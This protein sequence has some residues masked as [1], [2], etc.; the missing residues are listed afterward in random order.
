M[1]KLLPCLLAASALAAGPAHASELHV[2]IPKLDRTAEGIYASVQVE[3]KNGWRN[4]RNYDAVWLLF[5]ASGAERPWPHVRIAGTGHSV[6]A[7]AGPPGGV[8]VA[9]G[10]VGAFLLPTADHRGPVKWDVRLRLNAR[11]V[12]T[13][14][15][16]A[17]GLE[18]VYV[19]EGAF[20]LGDPDPAGVDYNAVYRS[21]ARGEPDGLYRVDSEDAIAVGP[22]RGALFYKTKNPQFEGDRLGPIPAAFPKGVAPFYT[23]KYEITQGEYA[24]FLNTLGDHATAHRAIHGGHLY[25]ASRGTIRLDGSTYVAGAPARPANFIGWDDG[26]GFADWAGLRPMTE[27]EFTKAA[28][29]T[30]MPLP[31]DFPWGTASADR[32][33]RVIGDDDDL[34]TTGAAD[35]STLSDATR[36][37]L[38]ASFYWVMDLAGS[39][40]EKVITFGHPR[41]RA[42]RGTHGDGHL[43]DRGNATNDDWPLG[44]DDAGGYGYRG[45]GYYERGMKPREYVPYSPTE[46]RRYGSWGGGPRSIAYGFRAVR[47]A[48]QPRPDLANEL[49]QIAAASGGTLGVRV[50]HAETRAAAG[51]NDDDWYP[52]MSAYKLPIAI[53]ALRQAEAGRLNLAKTVT[54]GTDDRR[55]GFSP[56]A[57]LIEKDGPQTMTLRDLLSAILRVSDNTASDRVLREIGGPPAVAATL[58]ELRIDGVDVSRSELQ[59]AADYYGVKIPAPYSLERFIDATERVPP[60]ARR[61]AAAAY[62]ADRRDAAQPR[63]FADLLVRFHRGE[64]LT[65]ENTAWV[66]GEMREMHARDTRLRAGLPP[67]TAAALRPGTSGETDGVRAAHNDNAIVTLPDG[68]HLVIAAFLKGSKGTD[69]DRDAVLARVARVAYAWATR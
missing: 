28:R 47:T 16:R 33:A 17:F 6:A 14:E 34:V 67:G 42:F 11:D 68:S 8:A 52:M 32:L 27:L 35:E 26:L 62:L 25:T 50:V 51:V 4:G 40:W 9:D 10:G 57:R 24:A 15:V 65:G 49:R 44:D 20:L 59:F 5:K 48:P 46:W 12:G 61:R 45:G 60:A 64:L 37:V 13:D 7:V 31:H 41:G 21:D 66:I 69:A 56:L 63:A 18:M 36:D 30:A 58:R 38:G 3:W 2:S 54:L 23:M 53:H 22:R 39:V 55:P 19:P 1:P 43:T 29:G